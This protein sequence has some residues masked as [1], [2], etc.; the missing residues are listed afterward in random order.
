MLNKF[1]I[2]IGMILM[3]LFPINAQIFKYI[4][5]DNGLSSRRVLSIEQ[6]KQYYIWILTHKGADRYDGKRFT[7]YNL[8]RE[9][10]AL[11]FYPNLNIL[12]T[13]Q[14]KTV[15]EIGKDGFLFR[16]D[17]RKDSFLLMFDLKQRY[18]EFKKRPVSAI[19][20]DNTDRIWFC[21]DQQIVL[22]DVHK[23]HSYKSKHPF[24][25]KIT[26]ITQVNDTEFYLTT[27]RQV[28]KIHLKENQIQDTELI[29]LP[30]LQLIDYIYYHRPSSKLIINSLLDKLF[31]YNPQNGK[32][33]S[34]GESM[35]DI[36]INKIIPDRLH[37]DILYIATDGKGVYRLD[38][39][40]EHL[41]P[42]L[43]ED[44]H[45]P[46]KMNGNIIKDI[47][48]DLS[49]R[50]WNVVYPTGLTV[51]SEQYPSYKWVKHSPNNPHSL[52]NNCINAILEDADGDIWYATSNGISC[53]KKDK[54]Q[55]MNFLTDEAQTD[56][57][58][59]NRI[60]T[61]L[62]EVKP[63]LVLAGGYMSGIYM[64]DKHTQATTFYQQHSV[65]PDEGPDKY[66]RCIY[67]D[68]DGFVWTGGFYR[69]K[70][71]NP[72]AHTTTEYNI[73]Y[74][75]TTIQQRDE[76][77]LWIGTINGVYIFD[78]RNQNFRPLENDQMGC[79]N[80]VYT[81]SAQNT[82][83]GTYGNGLFVLPKNKTEFIHYHTENSGIGS[84]NIYS[85][86][87]DR[88]GNL[89]I[90]TENGLCFF[91][92][93]ER[94]F[95][96][97]TK[98]QGLLAASFNPNAAIHTH[99]GTLI[100]GSNDGAIVLHD[101]IK[102]PN[103][104]YNHIV[105][106]DLKIMY[107]TVHPDEKDSPL[108][109]PL[110]QTEQIKL[111]YDQ[112]TFS[113]NVSSINFDNPSNVAYTWKLEGFYDQWS[114]A[115]TDGLIQYTNLSPGNYTLRVQAILTDSHQLIEER[116]IRI[117]IGRPAWLTFW[118]FL[119]YAL[120]I[121]GITWLI[122]RIKMIR[123]EKQVSQ[124]KINFFVHTAHDIRTPLTLIKAPLG[125][126][127]KDEPLS[128]QGVRNLNLAMQNTENL[129]ELANNLINF[130][131]ES[132]YSPQ[133]TV[134][135]QELNHYLQTYLKQ[136][137]AYAEQKGIILHYKGTPE[138][139]EV[140][141]DRNKI[142]SI[143]R[144]LISNALKYTPGGGNINVEAGHTKNRWTLS[145]Q[146][147]GIGIPKEDQKKLFRFLFRGQNATNQ[148]IT[149]SGIGMLLTYRLIR[150]HEG[151]INCTSTE[152]V[153]TTFTLSFPIRSE[154]FQY[155]TEDTPSGVL[156]EGKKPAEVFGDMTHNEPQKPDSKLPLILIVED[157]TGLR[158]FLAESLADTY[159]TE[160]AGNGQEAL[161]K[162]HA[163]PPDLVISDVMM[164]V[165]NGEEMCSILKSNMETSHIPV[166]LLTALGTRED[167][168][169]GLQTKADM[170]IVKPF[171]LTVLK[172]NISNLL[173]NRELIRKKLK[174][175]SIDME[176]PAEDTL[177]LPELDK[178]FIHK[179]TTFIKENLEGELT[180]DAI[181]AEM[182]MSRTS[183]YN[184]M[185]GLTGIPPNEFIRNIRMQ[186][187]AILLKT[188]RYT[189]AEV[190]DRM[191]FADPKY[192]ADAFK[193]FYGVPPS[194]Y[195]KND[196]TAEDTEEI[197]G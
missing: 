131:K 105:F 7:H 74:P 61:S 165:M 5:M 4:G 112:N 66:I 78:K 175:A 53:Y 118:A 3:S 138:P 30:S 59:E 84:D 130:Q 36:G 31:I 85:I 141:I 49:G 195:K 80:V 23:K 197:K 90:G 153:G 158:T 28:G 196:F 168:L 177:L 15:Y 6:G 14:D 171:D 91:D 60:F 128:E 103:E 169:R 180:V 191:G 99:D 178:E 157:N 24:N 135:R 159:R 19:Y 107:R 65:T 69:L 52:A 64:I 102:L 86:V 122:V 41:A 55:W 183:F 161:D 56:D 82:Y 13:S 92:P 70:T 176:P 58:S 119:G 149:G 38:V 76:H 140:W 190:S 32:L 2:L 150:N 100:F 1:F 167:I 108:S 154:H 151:K 40:H 188:Q 83:I 96:N 73:G 45:T 114:P 113:L 47:Y 68:T 9:G 22:Y 109:R 162:I 75:V 129:S 111:R 124:E 117:L 160:E 187:A 21:I 186:E 152:G 71:H 164:P 185:K 123:H 54:R 144:N 26:C 20:M 120:I 34:M 43:C 93:M 11:N 97:W 12:H 51:Y 194:V 121:I 126:I 115:T 98:E 48:Q 143:L 137:E 125:E 29:N 106:T 136:F 148:L 139:L 46:N 27:E 174:Q 81:D 104:F 145:I 37:P 50:L 133:A 17:E 110:D 8:C 132:Y 146:D 44:P 193:K 172:A 16:Y 147:T 67:R 166:I 116:D 142:D 63:G 72:Q 33:T 95:T 192:F 189:V 156:S 163:T 155:R 57:E 181:C 79:V 170:H 127:L 18:P 39:S 182:N 134:S 25:G 77:S 42:F 88:N 179:V 62:C 184:K 94:T 87:S 173:E 89:Y 101:N 35:K 10:K